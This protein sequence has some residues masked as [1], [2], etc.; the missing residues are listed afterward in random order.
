MRSVVTGRPVMEEILSDKESLSMQIL[1]RRLKRRFIDNGTITS[2]QALHFVSSA[3]GERM[4]V[5]EIGLIWDPRV[6]MVKPRRRLVK[7]T[8]ASKVMLRNWFSPCIYSF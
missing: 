2:Q 7:K 3:T 1:A 4:N 6:S 5:H 8:T